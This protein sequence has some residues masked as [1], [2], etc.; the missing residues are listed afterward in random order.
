VHEEKR[1]TAGVF[2]TVTAFVTAGRDVKHVANI[3][4]CKII[5]FIDNKEFILPSKHFGVPG[6]PAS[7][8]IVLT[9]EHWSKSQGRR[10]TKGEV[11]TDD[12]E[13]P[14]LDCI[15]AFCSFH[16]SFVKLYSSSA[17]VVRPRHRP[18]PPLYVNLPHSCPTS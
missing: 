7:V 4:V 15:P 12:P 18:P 3:K 9:F 8:H 10:R 11:K 13:S 17:R 6:C 5:I 1:A 14:N 2:V 16:R